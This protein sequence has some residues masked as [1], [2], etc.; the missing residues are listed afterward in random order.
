MYKI[1]IP[2]I[3]NTELL[4][5]YKHIKPI[6]EY[7][8]KKYF[9]REFKENELRQRPFTYYIEEDIKEEV[10][11]TKYKEAQRIQEFECIHK[12]DCKYISI[13]T[14]KIA[15][16]IAQIPKCYIYAVDAFEIMESYTHKG[17]IQYQNVFDNGFNVSRVRLYVKIRD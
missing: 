5:R 7:K 13:F 17:D 2:K 16:I 8:G 1:S 4:E 11:M 14:P 6:I 15:E 12:A 10:D 9:L 3:S